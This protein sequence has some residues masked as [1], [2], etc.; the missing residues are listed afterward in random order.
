[1]GSGP[2]VASRA[3]NQIQVNARFPNIPS[4]NLAEFKQV[5]ARALEIARGEAGTLQYAWF[6]NDAETSCVVRETYEDSAAVLAHVA[7]LGDVF[8]Q[9]LEVGGGC[10]FEVF[11]DPSSELVEA[12]RGLDLSIFAYFQGK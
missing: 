1:M 12:T 8:G 7:N 9:L 10:E 3:M 4:G 6:F 2:L 5:A 11:G